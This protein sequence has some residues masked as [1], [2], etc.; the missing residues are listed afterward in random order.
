MSEALVL[1]R[2][3]RQ[4]IRRSFPRLRRRWVTIEWGAAEEELLAYR[5][6][7]GRHAIRVNDD[8]RRAPRRVLEGGI[9]HELC[10]IDADLRLTPRVRD[11]SWERY[12]RSRWW[13]IRE[14][15][16]TD[17]R[18][19]DLGYGPQLFAFLRYVRG[20]GYTLSRE[21]GLRPGE[22]IRAFSAD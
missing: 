2:V 6:E 14:E 18:V 19:I 21:H 5:V 3:V 12:E 15:R 9:A 11:L 7:G 16:A 4:M 8:L 10:H 22:V 13:R 17:E 1:E 20:I